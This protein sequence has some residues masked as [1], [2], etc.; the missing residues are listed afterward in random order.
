MFIL[1]GCNTIEPLQDD[2]IYPPA[3]ADIEISYNN[4]TMFATIEKRSD[5]ES[6]VLLLFHGTTQSDNDRYL[7][8]N[9]TLNNF[10]KILERQDMLIISVAYPQ[11]NLLFGD[12]IE[13]AEAALLWVKNKAQEQL[14]IKVKKIYLGGHSQGGYLVTRLNTMHKTDG[15]IANAPGPLNLVYRCQLEENGT[16]QPGKVCEKLR[17]EYG[18][19]SVNAS[20]YFDRSLLNYTKGYLADI[21]FVQ[22]LN[23]SPIQ[24]Y[25]W[26]TFNNE[27]QNC[28]NCKQV[29]IVEIPGGE[30]AS[31]FI[32]SIG[33]SAFNEF[34]KKK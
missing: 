31:M 23:D 15:V 29:Q 32:D 4:K 1:F 2:K 30:H 16:I 18:S 28:K 5:I 25:S 12:N 27:V 34:I 17:D 6:D 8:A 21:L 13:Y 33:I 3:R 14:G 22:G 7:A 19:T 26:P 24:M 10:V 9:T 20:A 11:E